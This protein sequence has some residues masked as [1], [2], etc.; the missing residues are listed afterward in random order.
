MDY[1]LEQWI[2]GPAGSS[3]VLDTVMRDAANWGQWIFAGIVVAW[4]VY[5]W[6][7]GGRRDR[8]GAIAA[9]LAAAIALGINQILGHL[10]VRPRP[11]IAHPDT[12]H[13][14]IAHANDGS[15]PSDHAAAGVAIAMTLWFV[16][17]RWGTL[18]L[19]A[20]VVMSYA[21]VFDGVHYPGDVLAGAVIGIAASW[22][23]VRWGERPLV[24]LETSLDRGARRLHLPIPRTD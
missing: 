2:N 16:H 24:A 7:W 4:L 17:R 21:R 11:F 23:V 9:L 18:A 15:F 5:G 13:T 3:S 14:L 12:V 22:M 20:A 10:W 6:I 8:W 19:M 1:Q